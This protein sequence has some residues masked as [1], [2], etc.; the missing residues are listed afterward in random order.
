MF[1]TDIITEAARQFY[2]TPAEIT[3][4]SRTKDIV[5]ARFALYKAMRGRG[6]SLKQ[7]ARWVGQRDH[8]AVMNGLKRADKLL[9]AD[10]VYREIIDH[11]IQWKRPV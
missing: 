8:T 7:I 1:V 5:E 9:A 3:G 6:A 2:M 10:E 11:L 4:R